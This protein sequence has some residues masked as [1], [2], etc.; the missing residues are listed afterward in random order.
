MPF[1]PRGST[2]KRALAARHVTCPHMHIRPRLELALFLYKRFF[3]AAV[4][5]GRHNGVGWGEGEG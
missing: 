1:K 2:W 3:D 5:V 4:D